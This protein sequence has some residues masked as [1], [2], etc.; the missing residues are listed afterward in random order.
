MVKRGIWVVVQLP[1]PEISQMVPLPSGHHCALLLQTNIKASSLRHVTS[2]QRD[3]LKPLATCS[4]C[5]P[6]MAR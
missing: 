2:V 1:A 6:S 3:A 5:L 4:R